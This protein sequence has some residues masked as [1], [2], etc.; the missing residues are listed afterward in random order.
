MTSLLLSVTP[1]LLT[2]QRSTVEIRVEV[3]LDSGYQR[4][5]QIV[6]G[7]TRCT[8]LSGTASI[9][10]TYGTNL[11]SFP[12]QTEAEAELPIR[13]LRD[14]SLD[15]HL[16]RDILKDSEWAPAAVQETPSRYA[17]I[18]SLTIEP[19]NNVLKNLFKG[20]NSFYS[21]GPPSLAMLTVIIYSS[22]SLLRLILFLLAL[23]PLQG[24]SFSSECCRCEEDSKGTSIRGKTASY[25]LLS[26]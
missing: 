22:P 14:V 6:D 18:A 10:Q 23:S 26:P 13:R 5:V 25:L 20:F 16:G 15:V 11:L 9:F 8:D 2:V 4:A 21:L 19:Y 3:S 24:S 17:T 12:D 7:N 1:P